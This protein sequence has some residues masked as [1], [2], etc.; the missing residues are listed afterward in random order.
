MKW[1]IQIF[2]CK[3]VVK[4]CI[5]SFNLHSLEGCEAQVSKSVCAL[6]CREMWVFCLPVTQKGAPLS[7]D[8]S[9]NIPDEGGAKTAEDWVVL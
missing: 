9:G 4:E 6:Q 8:Y 7:L 2:F 1:G 5:F 3:G